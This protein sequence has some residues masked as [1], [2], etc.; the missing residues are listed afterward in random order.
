[1]KGDDELQ[2]IRDA[3]RAYEQALDPVRR[4]QLG[5]FFSGVPLGKLL[6]HLGIGTDTRTVLDPMAGHGDLLDAAWDAATER[7]IP[8]ERIDGIEI[9]DAIAATCRD[10]LAAIL[11]T[12]D[13]AK[14]S[15]LGASAFDPATLNALPARSYDM[16]ITNPPFV[17]YQGR[18]GHYGD[19]DPA[20]SGLT[21]IVESFSAGKSR[22][23][24]YT[25]AQGYSGLADLSVPAWILAGLMVRPGGRLAL[26]V[27][28]TWRSRDYADVVRYLLLRCFA[29]EI[30]VA[31]TQPGWFSD[32]LVRTHLIVAQRL[33]HEEAQLP[34]RAK[35]HWP[36]ARWLQVA[37]N[38]AD[39]RSLVGAAFAGAHPEAAFTTWVREASTAAVPG[40][41]VRNFDLRHEWAALKSRISRRRWYRRLEGDNQDLPLF[42]HG[43][44]RSL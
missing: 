32:A 19:V 42:S 30:I 36:A 18:D 4:K 29:V 26:V 13:P 34:L 39:R 35:N 44:S 6:A 33:P 27:P 3:A 7:S 21:K 2:T 17:R 12:D 11:G 41:E 24:W 38:A 28:A 16:V 40:I 25:L 22:T 1:M 10:R 43:R 31:D 14:C 37:P 9:D 5:Q 23:V 20:R 15:I 8:L